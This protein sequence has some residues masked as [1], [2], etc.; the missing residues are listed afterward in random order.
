LCGARDLT[1]CNNR[2]VFVKVLCGGPYYIAHHGCVIESAIDIPNEFRLAALRARNKI[3]TW[4]NGI[5]SRPRHGI[6]L[7][8]G[9]R[10]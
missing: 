10:Q 7:S 9:S 8:N 2:L 4:V 6:L 1:K 5:F 3:K